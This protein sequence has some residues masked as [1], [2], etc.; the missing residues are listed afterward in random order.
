MP[1]KEAAL[2]D[3]RDPSITASR[4]AAWE[5]CD[6]ILVEVSRSF[7]LIIPQCPPPIDRALC[8]AYLLCRI[9]DTIEDEPALDESHKGML[10]DRFLA[11]VDRPAEPAPVADFLAG[12]PRGMA[13][14]DPGYAELIEGT[15]QVLAAYQTLPD[16]A[17]KPIRRCVQ[18]MVAGMRETRSFESRGGVDFFC[19]DL[20]DLD[21]YCHIVA[22]TVG[23][24]S[25]ALFEWHI[26][27]GAFTADAAWRERGR[28][29]GLGLQMTNII[30]DCRVDAERGVSFIPPAYVDPAAGRYGL[31]AEAKPELFDHA[32]AHLDAGLEYTLAM[33]AAQIGIRRFLLGSLLPAVATLGVSAAETAHHPR[34]SREQM[35]EILELIA[36][37]RIKDASVRAWYATHRERT[38]RLCGESPG[39]E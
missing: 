36:A 26:A 24:M 20:S 16:E 3:S 32:L 34:I 37:D 5:F 23:V 4:A 22:G 21:G 33:P 19:R 1:A 6:R 8:N 28:R 25:T 30:K 15:G 7:A 17:R 9:A 31:L 35:M 11:C 10:F 39:G 14:S 12:W 27:R 29:L 2:S 38:R 13:F 18:E